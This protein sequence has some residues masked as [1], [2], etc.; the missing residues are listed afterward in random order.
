MLINGS[1]YTGYDTLTNVSRD[2]G[3]NLFVSK[4]EENC[5]ASYFPSSTAVV[6]CENKG[7][8]SFV[9]TLSDSFKNETRG[10]MGTW[11]DDT[12]DDFTLPNGTVLPPSLTAKQIHF[13]F[14]VKCKSCSKISYRFL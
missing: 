3:G 4:T 12:D 5:L 6:F 11:N 14:G 13:D 2:V 8:L 7:M 9:V 10:L 1:L